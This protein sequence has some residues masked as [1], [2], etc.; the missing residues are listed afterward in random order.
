M[1]FRGPST[2]VTEKP[3]SYS[4]QEAFVSNDD[5]KKDF[6]DTKKMFEKPKGNSFRQTPLDRNLTILLYLKKYDGDWKNTNE[7]AT[8][9]KGHGLHRKRLEEVLE[10]LVEKELLEKQPA[11]NPQAK[12]EYKINDS[13]KDT[14]RKYLIM[15]DD[16]K[17]KFVAGIKREKFDELD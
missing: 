6:E 2:F 11:E 10:G 13:G 17:M 4:D 5:S 9:S 16:P 7:I 14:L 3:F 8:Y 1:K 12:F 15:L